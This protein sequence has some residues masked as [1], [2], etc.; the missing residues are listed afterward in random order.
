LSGFTYDLSQAIT[1]GQNLPLSVTEFD[2][3]D[4]TSVAEQLNYLIQTVNILESTPSVNYYSWFYARTSDPSGSPYISLLTSQPGVLSALG[5]AYVNMPVHEANVYYRPNGAL[6][7]DRYVTMANESIGLTG[8][9]LPG[10]L[11]DM[12]STA[13]D[14]QLNYNLYAAQA[15][16]YDVDLRV[17]GAAGN[18]ELLNGTTPL[19]TVYMTGGTYGDVDTQIYLNA[20]YDSLTVEFQNTG[21]VINDLDFTAVPEPTIGFTLLTGAMVMASR[22]TRRL[23]GHRSRRGSHR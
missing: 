20:G 22:R 1:N 14:A 16:L 5:N 2:Y 18:I 21:Q 23:D 4:A 6:Q 12:T 11:A 7:A 10:I 3:Y 15:G 9:T 13:P 17:A 8:D 19:N